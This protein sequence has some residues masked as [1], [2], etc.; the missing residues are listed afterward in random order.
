MKNTM[1]LAIETYS[2]LNNKTFNS[3][4]EECNKGNKTVIES[5]KMLMFSVS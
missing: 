3:V 4:V 1:T 2:K 5:I